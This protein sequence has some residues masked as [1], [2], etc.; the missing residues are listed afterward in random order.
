MGAQRLSVVSL[1]LAL[2]ALTSPAPSSS[3][4]WSGGPGP[5]AASAKTPATAA[6]AGGLRL[7]RIGRFRAPVYLTAPPGDGRRLFVVER[8]GRVRVVRDGRRLGPAFLDISRLVRTDGE[9][10]LLSMAFAPDYARSRRFYVYFTDNRGDLRLQELRRSRGN[11]DRAAGGTRRNVMTIRHRA[12]S[13]HNGG[14]V[15]FGPDGLLYMGPGDGG[16]S[17]DPERNAQNPRSRLGKILRIDPRRAG[18]RAY[19]V[20]RSNPRFRTRGARREIYSYGLRNP[21]RFSFDRQTGDLTIGDVG[22][23]RVEEVDYVRRGRGRGAN[24]GWNRFEGRLRF[25][26]GRARGHVP[27][28]IQRFH[29]EGNCSVI[30]GYVVRDRSLPQLFGRYLY[31]DLCDSRLRSALLRPGRARE[32]R[33]IGLS[34]PALV[35]FG[36]DARGRVYAISIRGGVFR[37]VR[38]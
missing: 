4:A 32:D 8:A 2:T 22:E 23:G 19:R 15:A 38:R 26:R 13:N 9:R 16:G 36:E 12:H 21:Y 31:G 17:G 37:L 11:P 7:V 30:G 28:V 10:G 5:A 34:V 35:S 18:R 6:G 1:A 24:F 3:G 33:A 27:P 20:P 14:Q 25:A 29:R